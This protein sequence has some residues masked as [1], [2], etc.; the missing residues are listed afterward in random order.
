V[1]SEAKSRAG[2]SDTPEFAAA[3]RCA[4]VPNDPNRGIIASWTSRLSVKLRTSYY[5]YY[6]SAADYFLPVVL[7]AA[8]AEQLI[9][10]V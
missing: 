3:V 1:T 6:L 2:T 7:A 5:H 4:V 10:R 9:V 8:V